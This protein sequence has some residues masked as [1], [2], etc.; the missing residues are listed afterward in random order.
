MRE[1]RIQHGNAQ[2]E[3]LLNLSER[4]MRGQPL[5]AILPRLRLAIGRRGHGFAVY[6]TEIATPRGAKIRVD[7]SEA[8]LADHP[9]WRA[10]T[11]HSVAGTR[12]VGQLRRTCGPAPARR[13][14]AAMLAHE[15]KNPLSGIRGAAQVARVPV[16]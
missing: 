6:D 1:D 12:S 7:F 15:I 5:S 2:A 10:I 11:L 13:G 3:L 16:N 4:V 9:G 8:Q 14:A